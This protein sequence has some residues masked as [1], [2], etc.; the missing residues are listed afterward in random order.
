[1][2][3]RNLLLIGFLL[4]PILAFSQIR[5]VQGMKYLDEN[6]RPVFRGN[7]IIPNVG[8]YHVLKCD[9]HTHTVFSDGHVWPNV[10]NQE[11][12]EEGLDSYAITDHV[13]YTPHKADVNV[14]HN[15]GYEL[16]KESADKSNLI[17]VKGTEI[18]RNTPPGHFNAIYIN[19]ASGF[20]EDR[21]TNEHDKAAVMKAAEQDA[22]IFWNHPGWQPGIE[23]SYEW[24]PFVDD[25]YKNKALHGIEVVNGFGIHIKALDWCLDK[26]LTVM[27]TSDIHNLVA[28]DYDLSKDYVHRTMTLVLAKERSAESIREALDEGR[29]V[30]WA[31]KYLLGKEDNV[32]ALFNACVELMPAHFTETRNNGS[33]INHYEIRNNSDLYFELSLTDGS[34]NKNVTLYPRST[35]LI[36]A[37]EEAASLTGEVV[38]TYV[39]SDQHLKVNFPLN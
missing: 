16:L 36:T 4:I 6:K 26:G 39:R 24:I 19:D 11:V 8:E 10:R 34:T 12:W 18:T 23:G 9:F 29:T 32:R 5:E 20:I 27:G 1:M 13:E 28:H 7:V 3:Q 15:R 14:N 38:S 33:K 17:L 25:L 22:F 30:A 21:A 2:K 35:Q 31:S 37:N